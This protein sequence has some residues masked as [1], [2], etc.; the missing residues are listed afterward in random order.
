M[1]CSDGDDDEDVVADDDDDD[2]DNDDNNDNDD[3]DDNDAS[4]PDDTPLHA[5]ICQSVYPVEDAE[6]QRDTP[7]E[8]ALAE[9]IERVNARLR[10][11][12]GKP[13]AGYA[14]KLGA[15]RQIVD[16][17]APRLRDALNSVEAQF[18]HAL[19][20]DVTAFLNRVLDG[21]TETLAQAHVPTVRAVPLAAEPR[22]DYTMPLTEANVTR[23]WTFY[24]WSEI[25]GG[26]Y[27]DSAYTEVFAPFER[28]SI[29]D[30]EIGTSGIEMTMD[31]WY[32]PEEVWTDDLRSINERLMWT[33]FTMWD[34]PDWGNP[35]GYWQWQPGWK[36]EDCALFTGNMM[37]A[38]SFEY[39]LTRLPRTLARLQAIYRAVQL[40]D[41]YQLDGEHPLDR[42]A[43]DGRIQRGPTTK[44]FY[45]EQEKLIFDI[46]SWWP[47]EYTYGGSF[48]DYLTGRERKNV[49]RDQYYGVILGY[50]GLFKNFSRLTD[51]TREEIELYCAI[52]EHM[53]LMLDYL[54]GPRIL[55]DH[56]L[57]YNL[58]ALFEGALANPP[59]LTFM[60]F[61]AYPGY[62]E[63]T[64]REFGAIYGLGTKLL[65][66]L[67][68]LAAIFG[69]VD[70]SQQLFGP[71]QSGLTALNQYMITLYL[72]NLTAAEWQFI[73]PPEV[74]I[75][76]PE[77]YTLWRRVIA[78]FYDK[79]GTF[80]NETYRDVIDTMVASEI[81]PP[82]LDRIAWHYE[83][84]WVYVEPQSTL[85][86]LLLPLAIV[87]GAAANQ[88]ELADLLVSQYEQMVSD[89]TID[90]SDTDLPYPGR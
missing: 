19:R 81:E 9:A 90:F 64:G 17:D 84:G 30:E 47:F 71:A 12:M 5:S 44:N 87:A 82:T 24:H 22:G 32:C 45:P 20:P 36:D 34:N 86:D 53:S 37:G 73:Y 43:I 56:G 7:A 41:S 52:V 35:D 4:P 16:Q 49:S 62:E 21:L 15:M 27:D 18:G 55:L 65:H 25:L 75:E 79:Y 50:Y 33:K 70:L 38:L 63:M 14:E 54:F 59:N 69:G 48:P 28:A 42:E 74:L 67:F 8:L 13:G 66:A 58:Y 51:A 68:T 85:E 89:G 1:A 39:R 77:R 46:T 26:Y 29:I 10:G 23:Y 57:D 3:D 11:A 31:W 76:H 78:L 80:A 60:T 6:P 40:F 61:W 2:D 83:D 88:D 72:S